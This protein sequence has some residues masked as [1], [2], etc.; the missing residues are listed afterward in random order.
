MDIQF[1]FQAG[2]FEFMQGFWK[3]LYPRQ[4]SEHIF[5][6]GIRDFIGVKTL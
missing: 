6:H 4:L 1:P 2:Q 3:L 5:Q